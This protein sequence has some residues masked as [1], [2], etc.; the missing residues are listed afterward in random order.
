MGPFPLEPHTISIAEWQRN[1]KLD[2]FSSTLSFKDLSN[3]N[4]CTLA[5]SAIWNWIGLN[6]HFLVDPGTLQFQLRRLGWRI[7]F[8][9]DTGG[10]PGN[11]GQE[12]VNG[13]SPPGHGGTRLVR[14]ASAVGRQLLEKLNSARKNFPMKIFLLLLGFYMANALARILGQTGDWYALVAGVMV[15]AI[16]VTGQPIEIQFDVVCWNLLIL[17]LVYLDEMILCIISKKMLSSCLL[18]SNPQDS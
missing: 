5:L 4:D 15:A 14:I 7:T 6:V 17:C 1:S 11:G 10:L 8:S 16:R 13:D 3:N 9:L 18:S 12:S 2:T